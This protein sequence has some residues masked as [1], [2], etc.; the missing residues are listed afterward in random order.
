M[1]GAQF[2]S[3]NPFFCLHCGTLLPQ[4]RDSAD[5]QC[6]R[7]KATR[8]VAGTWHM[9][10][11]P[12]LRPKVSLTRPLVSDFQGVKILSKSREFAFQK[13]KFNTHVDPEGASS[14]AKVRLRVA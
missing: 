2:H 1:D 7:C 4:P 9:S 10:T 14:G 6:P 8:P 3:E 5:V 12:L 11:L 13:P